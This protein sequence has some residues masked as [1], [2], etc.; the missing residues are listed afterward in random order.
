MDRRR[1]LQAGT[2]VGVGA[3]LAAHPLSAWAQR[4]GSPPRSVV[5]RADYLPVAAFPSGVLSGDPTPTGWSSGPGSPLLRPG[6]G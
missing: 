2:S 5:T 4:L 1:F 3:A 6:P